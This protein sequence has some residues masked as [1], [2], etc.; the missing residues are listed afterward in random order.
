MASLAA[1]ARYKR[2][3]GSIA[4]RYVGRV[5]SNDMNTDTIKG[6]P[7]AYDPYFVLSGSLGYEF[8]SH[9]TLVLS[10]DNLLDRRYYEYYRMPG[11]T[12]SAGLRFRLR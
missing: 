12:W 7:G 5:F 9:V 3:N 6:V 11:R 1:I 10:A 8:E 4:A 2:G